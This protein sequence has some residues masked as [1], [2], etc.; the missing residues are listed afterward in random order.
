[1]KE[2]HTAVTERSARFSNVP[3]TLIHIGMFNID[4]GDDELRSAAYDLLGAVCSYLKYHKNSIVASKGWCQSSVLFHALMY[5]FSS[6]FYSW[7]SERF[8]G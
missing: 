4:S 1:M 2:T 3:A 8:C 5:L 7:R 6:G